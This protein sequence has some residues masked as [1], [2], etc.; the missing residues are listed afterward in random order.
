VSKWFSKDCLLL[1]FGLS[2]DDRA[3]FTPEPKFLL[4]FGDLPGESFIPCFDLDIIDPLIYLLSYNLIVCLEPIYGEI[5]D[6]WDF[7][8]IVGMPGFY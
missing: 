7:M 6:F 1:D 5:T 2:T 4:S 3:K 8:F